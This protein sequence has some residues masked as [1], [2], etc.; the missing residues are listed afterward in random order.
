MEKFFF[1]RWRGFSCVC[2]HFLFWIIIPRLF[3]ILFEKNQIIAE[4]WVSPSFSE[5]PIHTFQHF[6][7]P[8][9]LF[10]LVKQ[11][12]IWQEETNHVCCFEMIIFWLYKLI[13]STCPQMMLGLSCRNFLDNIR[14]S[15]EKS[16]PLPSWLRWW[17]GGVSVVS[18]SIEQ[19][20]HL[21]Y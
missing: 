15:F 20:N 11:R 12:H 4:Q 21:N 16:P 8:P 10:Y 1:V 19:R 6:F 9:K 13:I 2:Y 3:L 5:P 17:K 14:N 18:L 7:S